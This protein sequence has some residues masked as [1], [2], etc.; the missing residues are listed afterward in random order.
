MT[1]VERGIQDGTFRPVDPWLVVNH[2][3]GICTFYFNA[4]PNMR[5]VRPD[6]EWFTPEA[7]EQFTESAIALV[8]TGLRPTLEPGIVGI[9]HP[10]FL[11]P[12]GR[13]R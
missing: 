2:I 3:M 13:K 5:N 4:Q 10:P 12:A 9:Y 6:V 8:L 11:A 1:I 7:I